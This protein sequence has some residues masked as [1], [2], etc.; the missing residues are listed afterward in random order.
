[1]LYTNVDVT[2]T[3][4]HEYVLHDVL[5]MIHIFKVCVRI[6]NIVTN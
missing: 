1:M 2:N 5:D 6:F 4:K 3:Y